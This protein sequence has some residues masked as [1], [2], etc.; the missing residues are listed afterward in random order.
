MHNTNNFF[1]KLFWLEIT[2]NV[3][4]KSLIIKKEKTLES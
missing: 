4:D 1:K 3:I 2:L